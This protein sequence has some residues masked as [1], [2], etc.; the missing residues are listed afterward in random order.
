MEVTHWRKQKAWSKNSSLMDQC[1]AVV[2]GVSSMRKRAWMA[3]R[4]GKLVWEWRRGAVR[5][6]LE[7]QIWSKLMEGSLKVGHSR[8]ASYFPAQLRC[9]QAL[10]SRSPKEN[11][12]LHWELPELQA[13]VLDGANFNKLISW[14][15]NF[16]CFP[17][18]VIICAV[19]LTLK[20]KLALRVLIRKRQRTRFPLT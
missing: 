6:G 9:L 19:L 8:H 1:W 4:V 17:T 12:L 2:S 7:V 13:S 3:E 11:A 10:L 15:L 14:S 20:W 16:I 18:S 5:E